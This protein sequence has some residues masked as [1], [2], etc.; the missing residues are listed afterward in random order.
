M[1]NGGDIANYIQRRL[2]LHAKQR[3]TPDTAFTQFTC[4]DIDVN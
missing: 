3:N 2:K 4:L 1:N